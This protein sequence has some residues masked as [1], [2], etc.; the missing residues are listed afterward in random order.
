MVLIRGILFNIL[1]SIWGIVIPLIYCSVFITKNSEKA[2][3]GAKIWSFCI[4]WFLKKFVGINYEIRGKENLPEKGGF[5]IACKHQSMWDTYIMHLVFD[6]PVYVYKKELLKIPFYGW[7]ISKM[8]GIVVDREGGAKAL[9]NLISETKNYINKNQVVIIFPQGTRTSIGSN[10]R[11]YPYQPGIAALYSVIDAKIIPAALNSGLYWNKK[12]L[13]GKSGTIILEFLPEISAGLSK[14]EF[15]V[16]LENA[17]ETKSAQ[18]L[19]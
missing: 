4:A 8:S 11:D 1:V 7:F 14:K 9:K 15:M 6:R 16:A 19:Y 17:I 3:K 2:D 10:T 13:T 18:L 5:I 12:G